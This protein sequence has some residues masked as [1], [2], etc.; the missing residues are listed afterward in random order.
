MIQQIMIER[1]REI[2]DLKRIISEQYVQHVKSAREYG[3]KAGERWENNAVHV[4]R[5]LTF[6]S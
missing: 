6:F 5:L 1:N 2:S 4:H 3:V